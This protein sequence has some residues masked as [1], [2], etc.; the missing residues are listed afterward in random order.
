M[1][2][3]VKII[4]G[5]I[6][7]MIGFPIFVGGT[8]VVLLV[9]AFTDSRGYFMT[10]N[11]DINET[12]FQAVRMDI[13]LNYEASDHGMDI[14]KFITLKMNAFG[15]NNE[16]VFVGL[17]SSLDAD[18]FLDSNISYLLITNVEFFNDW[19]VGSKSLFTIDY[20]QNVNTSNWEQP[21]ITEISWLAGGYF[22][23]EFIW[24]PS[25]EDVSLD[26]ISLIIMNSDLGSSNEIDVTFR[27]G[28]KIPIINVI[29]WI[30]TVFGVLFILL[31]AVLLWSGFR[32]RKRRIDRIRYYQGAP[33]SIIKSTPEPQKSN[34]RLQCSNCGYL[35]EPDSSFCSQCGEVLLYEDRK[36]LDDSYKGN[37]V[38]DRSEKVTSNPLIV[39]DWGSRF[40]ALLIDWLVVGTFTSTTTSLFFLIFFN[41]HSSP[42]EGWL[43]VP[44]MVT[45]GPTSTLFFIYSVFMEYYHGQT[46][47]KMA[48]NLEVVSENDG[49]QPQFWNLII[50]AAGKSFFLP[51]DFILGRI[52]HEESAIPD[53][54]Q[55]LTQKWSHLVV[56][57][58]KDF[59]NYKSNLFVS[60]KL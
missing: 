24:A 12:G 42:I 2:S 48:L 28:A 21:N 54:N 50:S 23:T 22:D 35:N 57:R 6:I 47:G 53:L 46:L 32:S 17:C 33:A 52:F 16:E 44:W 10:N 29:G 13:P 8:A 27:I 51:I 19:N 36:T 55:R 5:L 11:V 39:A 59:S 18:K 34:Y 7:L 41:W 15:N 30:L 49:Q 58:K 60:D 14:S 43:S 37:K 45:V 56:I 9:P 4:S 31:A 1:A 25:F 20:E 40:W 38:I 3:L 26:M